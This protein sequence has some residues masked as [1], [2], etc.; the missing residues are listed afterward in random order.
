MNYAHYDCDLLVLINSEV[1]AASV[2]TRVIKARMDPSYL[3]GHCL[4]A[5]VVSQILSQCES[6]LTID[7][8]HQTH[9]HRLSD[10]QPLRLS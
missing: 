1:V 9:Y 3:G 4:L 8:C 5:F 7:A 2:L 10:R 6:F